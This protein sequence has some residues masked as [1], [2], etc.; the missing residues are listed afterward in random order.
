MRLLAPAL[1]AVS[2]LPLMLLNPPHVPNHVAMSY[3]GL[4]VENV[5]WIKADKSSEALWAAEQILRS[6]TCGA[7]LLWQNVIRNEHLRRLQLA[8]ASGST[9][10]FALQPLNTQYQASPATL[11]IAVRPLDDGV[12]ADIV[13]RKGPKLD[14]PIHLV[15][16]PSP[17]L[18]PKS[19]QPARE[20]ADVPV[21]SKQSV[22]E[23][24]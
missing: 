3:W 22:I 7:L 13:K 4:P 12:S 21:L 19:R 20:V 5:S 8:A 23:H 18:L 10:F 15:V 14:R 6:G 2:R 1:K 24:V 9:L 16:G 17:I 11:R